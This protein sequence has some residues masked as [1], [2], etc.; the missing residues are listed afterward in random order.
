MFW[1]NLAVSNLGNC[2][3]TNEQLSF[4][5][6][7]KCYS[8]LFYR[9]GLII[10]LYFVLFSLNKEM[11]FSLSVYVIIGTRKNDRQRHQ[12]LRRIYTTGLSGFNWNIWPFYFKL[13]HVYLLRFKFCTGHWTFFFAIYLTNNN[14]D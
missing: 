9:I 7:N 10:F 12:G 4:Y 14:N 3:G 2:F 8:I 6:S 5:D 13:C 1:R 11:F